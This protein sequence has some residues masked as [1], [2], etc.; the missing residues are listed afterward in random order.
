MLSDSDLDSFL[1]ISQR[2]NKKWESYKP[3][4][5]NFLEPGLEKP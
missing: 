2:Y 5:Q 3:E 4:S 1:F